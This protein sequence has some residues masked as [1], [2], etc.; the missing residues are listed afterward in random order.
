M[1]YNNAKELCEKNGYE[2]F[3]QFGRSL[4]KYI[5]C[6]PWCRLIPKDKDDAELYYESVEANDINNLDG[7]IGL[8]IGGIVEGSDVEIGP[9]FL[10]FPFTDEQLRETVENINEEAVFYWKRDNLSDFMIEVGGDVYFT[11]GV[12][13]DIEYVE[14]VP[15]DV[16]TF[17]EEHYD[18]WCDLNEDESIELKGY[19][20]TRIDKSMLIF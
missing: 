16:K 14:D 6:G 20:I 5:D 12:G 2:N 19:K 10:K 17:F 7:Y 1:Q 8:E 13:W 9:N 18:E 15:Q 11:D 3:Y 4:Y